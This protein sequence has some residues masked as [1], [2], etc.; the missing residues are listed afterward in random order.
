[1]IA[2]GFT[3]QNSHA[4]DGFHILNVGFDLFHV[5]HQAAGPLGELFALAAVRHIR[6]VGDE[7]RPGALHQYGGGAKDIHV[8]RVAG[9]PVPEDP[10]LGSGHLPSAQHDRSH[11]KAGG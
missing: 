5:A 1:M 7:P 3:E 8:Q 6:L 11:G 10:H 9:I 4:S 2:G